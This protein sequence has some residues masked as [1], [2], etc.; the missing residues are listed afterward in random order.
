L[1]NSRLLEKNLKERDCIYHPTIMFRNTEEYEY[2]GKFVY[3]EDHD[4]YL[5]I[6]SDGK[7]I[8]SIHESLVKYRIRN[9]TL[10]LERGIRQLFF[11]KTAVRFFNEREK[12]GADSYDAFDPLSIM[13]KDI[14]ASREPEILI[15]KIEFYLRKNDTANA[16]KVCKEYF[17]TN[18]FSS[19]VLAYFALTI[20]PKRFLSLAKRV[21]LAVHKAA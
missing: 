14:H 17:Q 16:K 21:R 10:E 5:R 15:P 3:A 19:K 6:L 20:L 9:A 12:S 8:A 4:F 7:K 11:S 18:G 13:K 2:R 1:T